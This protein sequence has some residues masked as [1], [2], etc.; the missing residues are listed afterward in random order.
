MS[1][2]ERNI[3]RTQLI[4]LMLQGFSFQKA[5]LQVTPPIKQAMAYRLTE[6]VRT[7]GEQ[8]L[9]DG[10][11]GHPFKVR[12][13]ILD[14]IRQRC[15]TN[16]L[17]PSPTLQHEL[18]QRFDCLISTSQLNRVR[19]RLGL[20]NSKTSPHHSKLALITQTE[21]EVEVEVEVEKPTELM[22]KKTKAST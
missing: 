10:R 12:G 13:Q 6:R 16:P 11:H 1:T 19:A 20:S 8:A 5:A 17:L 7:E 4:E 14:F 9:V 2:P 22:L 18:L 3:A 15:A 21:T